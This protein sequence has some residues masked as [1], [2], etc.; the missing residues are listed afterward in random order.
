MDSLS[1]YSSEQIY[2]LLRPSDDEDNL[3]NDIDTEFIAE[4]EIAQASRTQDT[5]LT[6]DYTR[7]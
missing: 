7:G 3:M 5:S 4:E 1:R 2:A 6:F